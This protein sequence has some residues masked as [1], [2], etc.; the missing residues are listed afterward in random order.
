[1]RKILTGLCGLIT[2]RPYEPFPLGAESEASQYLGAVFLD[3]FRFRNFY[4]KSYS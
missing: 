1:M 4:F 2:L 3:V